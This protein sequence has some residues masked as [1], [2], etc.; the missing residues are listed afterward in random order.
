MFE[1]KEQENARRKKFLAILEQKH[2]AVLSNLLKS[3]EFRFYIAELLGF[4][5]TFESAFNEK[6][7][8]AAYQNGMQAVGQKIF[9]DIMLI[10]PEAYLKMCK[11][12]EEIIKMASQIEKGLEVDDATE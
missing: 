2:N 12:E 4:C 8:V 9:N 11:E 3:Q 7:N 6:G 5:K 10:D 1:K